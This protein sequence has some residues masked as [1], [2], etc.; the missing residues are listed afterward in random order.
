MRA[1]GVAGAIWGACSFVVGPNCVRVRVRVR[2]R[3]SVPLYVCG[4][5]PAVPPYTCVL[6]IRKYLQCI[7][8]NTILTIFYSDMRAH[9][10]HPFATLRSEEEEPRTWKQADGLRPCPQTL[11]NTKPSSS[12]ANTKPFLSFDSSSTESPL[13]DRSYFYPL[14]SLSSPPLRHLS[15]TF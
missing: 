2:V 15:P 10:T 5:L 8:C 9:H 6:D 12:F 13:H 7:L 3:A 4:V 1:G 11:S 14:N